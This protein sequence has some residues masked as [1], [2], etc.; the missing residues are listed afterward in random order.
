MTAYDQLPYI[1]HP[2]V[3]TH[4]DHMAVLARLHGLD[5]P[6]PLHARILD[7]G[8]SEGGNLIPLAITMPHA[9]LVGIDL[10]A[11]PLDRGRSVV[12]DLGLANV[13]L[14]QLN[15][16]EMDDSFGTFDYIVAHGLYGWTPPQ[17]GDRLLAVIRNHLRP[18][19]IA[20]VSYNTMPGGHLR[21]L[22]REM[23]LFHAD[24]FEE[25]SHRIAAARAML[26]LIAEG[27]PD[28]D[29]IEQAVAYQASTALERTDSSLYHD[30]LAPVFEPVYFRDFAEHA[31]AHALAYVTDASVADTYNMKLSKQALEAVGAARQAGRIFQEQFLD[32]LRVR[33]FRRSLLCHNALKPLARWDSLR[34]AGLHAASAAEQSGDAEFTTPGGLRITVTSD[35]AAFLRDLIQLW[36]ASRPLEPHETN[37]ALELYRRD[38]IELSTFP[39][40]AVQAGDKPTASPLVRYQAQRGDPTV[41]TLRHRALTVEDESGRRLLALLDGAR[42][43]AQ[44]ASEMNC[45]PDELN[46]KLLSLQ[47]HAVLLG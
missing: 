26:E 3:Q 2:Y 19:G 18:Q 13:H 16:L 34:A 21:Q 35:V 25:P 23:M 5:A 22:V 27:V 6:S 30:Y 40:Q 14:V 39:S 33:R 17:I 11:I 38:L 44:L 41:S 7:I 42:D 4:P 24:R 8:T 43:R 15:L 12:A 10:A 31:L 37:L 28:P 46:Q 20:F 29:P 47:R 36:P 9:D 32:L 45:S 1:N